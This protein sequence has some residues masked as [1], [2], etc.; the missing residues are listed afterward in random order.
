MLNSSK[1]MITCKNGTLD[2]VKTILKID[3]VNNLDENDETCL[4]YALAGE[5]VETLEFLLSLNISDLNHKN[6]DG[7]TLTDL[8]YE[9]CLFVH[10]FNRHK[11][12]PKI[13][14]H[15]YSYELHR[16]I[17][18]DNL[19]KFK[20]L[21]SMYEDDACVLACHHNSTKIALFCIDIGFGINTPF[22]CTNSKPISFAFQNNNMEIVEK[23]IEV[24]DISDLTALDEK[25]IFPFEYTKDVRF[26]VIKSKIFEMKKI[27]TYDNMKFKVFDKTDIIQNDSTIFEGSYGIVKNVTIDGR[28]FKVKSYKP[29][30]DGFDDIIH[31]TDATEISL[32]KYLNDIDPSL[33]PKIYGIYYDENI[34]IVME[35]L[36]YTLNDYI[37]I[38]TKFN[39]ELFYK[40]FKSMF[41]DILESVKKLNSYGISH[42][43]LKV[44]NIMVDD[45]GNVKL[46]DF[47][48]SEFLGIG[49]R[50]AFINKIFTTSN[51]DPQINKYKETKTLNIDVFAVGVNMM[52]SLILKFKSL[53]KHNKY[54]YDPISKEFKLSFEQC[55]KELNGDSVYVEQLKPLDV[56]FIKDD[57]LID[58]LSKMLCTSSNER[59]FADDCLKHEFFTGIPYSPLKKEIKITYYENEEMR[60]YSKINN[61]LHYL[62][63][64]I[65]SCRYIRFDKRISDNTLFLNQC[66]RISY[67]ENIDTKD[68]ICGV[69]NMYNSINSV[70]PEKIDKYVDLYLYL[71]S[72]VLTYCQPYQPF[73]ERLSL[74]DKEICLSIIKDAKM[75]NFIPI[76]T[77]VHYIIVKLQILN[78]NVQ[79]IDFVK[80]KIRQR[81]LLWSI[82]NKI[83]NLTVFEVVIASY[84]CIE[85][86]PIIET[87]NKNYD[88]M[89]K[90]LEVTE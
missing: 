37:Y 71:S 72:F 13:G 7:M 89:N 80:T 90:V 79:F 2:D 88:H 22:K 62:E 49:P 52:N 64:I 9:K 25:K 28:S 4:F 85:G 69:S 38:I 26:D 24:L 12:C 8:D 27:K 16:I 60:S 31:Y 32:L 50:K 41:K 10:L 86:S 23:L 30:N 44:T 43:D 18:E 47:G 63:E 58:L 1:L 46:I 17:F 42:N 57:L 6:K 20:D 14:L 3:E 36:N 66:D 15:S 40:R 21:F 55:F 84:Y 29:Y 67:K 70:D 74:E 68:F 77:Y 48:I 51:I 83:Y 33:A 59:W 11:L 45:C 54:I 75:F 61:E 73:P 87:L 19:E 56:S 76:E 5:K 82:H 53:N 78:T 65:E 39:D 34:N 81:L 35:P